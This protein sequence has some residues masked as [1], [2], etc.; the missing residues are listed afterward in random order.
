MTEFTDGICDGASIANELMKDIPACLRV[1][2][3][4]DTLF[5]VITPEERATIETLLSAYLDEAI[6]VE[7][8]FDWDTIA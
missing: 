8:E 5:S 1:R 7:R 4:C 3:G 6:T 2:L